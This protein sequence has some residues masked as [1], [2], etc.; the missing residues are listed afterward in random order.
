MPWASTAHSDDW[1][2]WMGPK[3]DNVWRESGLLENF[4]DEGVKVLWRTTLA[5]GYAGP[6]VAN[7]RV[8]ISDYVTADDVQVPNFERQTFTGIERVLCMDQA[9]GEILWKHEYPVKYSVS[10]PAGPRCTPTIDG[11]RVYT[12][13]TEGHLFCFEAASGKV[14]WSKHLP[15][16]YNTTTA[17][18]GY[19]SHPL[20]DG[21]KLICVVGG[22]GSHAVAFNKLNGE[23]LWKTLT[24]KE[25]GYSP[26]TIIQ[27]GGKRQLILARPDAVSSVDPETGNEYWSVPYEATNGSIIMSPIQAGNLLFV[28]GYSNKNLLLQLEEEK[29]SASVL[30]QDENR[31]AVSPVN[32]QPILDPDGKTLYGYDQKGTL[33]GVDIAS[34]DRLWDS[35]DAVGGRPAGSETAFIYRVGDHYLLFT[36]KGDLVLAKLSREGYEEIDRTHVIDPTGVAFGRSVVWCAPAL[37]NRTLFVR[38]DKEIIA[39]SLAR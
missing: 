6:A 14:L 10:Y 38:N 34:G 9:N 13:G 23:E 37:A 15:A 28:A 33:H 21:E 27:A 17:L 16:E 11:E 29:P 2:Q 19:A 18:W 8:F 1:P 25:Q 5:G 31:K 12:L 4:P 22:N 20:I 35:T 30:W 7:G 32:V 36:E 39:V 24:S 3:R 26:P